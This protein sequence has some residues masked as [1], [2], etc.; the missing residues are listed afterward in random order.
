MSER[1]LGPTG[2]FG[3][4]ASLGFTAMGQELSSEP[5]RAATFEYNFS[6][7]QKERYEKF[8]SI[9]IEDFDIQIEDLL[10]YL[11]HSLARKINLKYTQISDMI[12]LKLDNRVLSDIISKDFLYEFSAPSQSKLP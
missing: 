1:W 4:R 10:D 6:S 11:E 5:P 12:D 2:L 9:I 7:S 8:K 3:Q